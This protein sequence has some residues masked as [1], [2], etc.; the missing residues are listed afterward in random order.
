VGISNHD[1]LLFVQVHDSVHHGFDALGCVIVR[2]LKR[3]DLAYPPIVQY[4][5]LQLFFDFVNEFLINRHDPC[6][7]HHVAT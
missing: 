2:V 1:Y 5:V 6:S 3:R 4:V 7:D